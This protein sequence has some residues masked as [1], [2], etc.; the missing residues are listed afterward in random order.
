[1]KLVEQERA[2]LGRRRL[3]VC[4]PRSILPASPVAFTAKTSPC[5]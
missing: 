2:S 5:R 1:V 4:Q 3:T